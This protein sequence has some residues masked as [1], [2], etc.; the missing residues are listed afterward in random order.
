MVIVEKQYV[1]FTRLCVSA[2]VRECGYPGACACACKYVHVALLILHATCMLQVVTSFVAPLSPPFFRHYLINGAIFGKTLLSTKSVFWFSLQLLS[3]TFLILRIIQRDIVINVKTSSCKVPV[4]LERF[5]WNFNFL[6][7]YSKKPKH[8]ISSKSV[9]W[10]SSC[11]MR[12]N[13]QK[14]GRTDEWKWRS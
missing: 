13:G 8:H 10:E 12:T 2:C 1:L 11:S 6:D 4:I 5:W 9:Q 7:R 14:D 3:K